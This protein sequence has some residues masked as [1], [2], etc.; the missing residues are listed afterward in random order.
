MRVL[1]ILE[2][3]QSILAIRDHTC[4]WR[5]EE[6]R[7]AGNFGGQRGDSRLS[8]SLLRLSECVASHPDAKT[9]HA[10]AR[11]RQL[12][13]NPNGRRQARGIERGEHLVSFVE[14]PDQYQTSDFDIPCL[15]GIGGITMLFEH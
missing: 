3:E 13:N 2:P 12:V 14:A 7:G 1:D 10:D 11:N 15:R 8:R 6:P 9:P 4:R 5:R